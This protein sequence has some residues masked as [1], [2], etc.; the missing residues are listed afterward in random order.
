MA[1]ALDILKATV[2]SLTLRS[3][4]LYCVITCFIS[5]RVFAALRSRSLAPVRRHAGNAPVRASA[6]SYSDIATTQQ[7]PDS[8]DFVLRNTFRGDSLKLIQDSS[9][10]EKISD[11][12]YKLFPLTTMGGYAGYYGGN[13]HP[14]WFIP[15]HSYDFPLYRIIK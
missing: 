3:S 1:F 10:M 8:G 13:R 2:S 5:S 4:G 9:R 7:K 15:E 14:C 6:R 11:F 12:R